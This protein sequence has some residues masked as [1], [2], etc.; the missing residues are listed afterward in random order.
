MPS[1]QCYGAH[2]ERNIKHV[3][4]RLF[5]YVPG[6]SKHYAAT[7]HHLLPNHISANSTGVRAALA[8]KDM[9]LYAVFSSVSVVPDLQH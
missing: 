2:E 6:T 9:D 1:A 5:F 8:R 4:I 3:S 7:V